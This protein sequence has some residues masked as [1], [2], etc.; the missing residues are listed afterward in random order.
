MEWETGIKPRDED[1]RRVVETKERLSPGAVIGSGLF[2]RAE[3][4][5]SKR[6][7][8][9]VLT[10]KRSAG[11]SDAGIRDD[12]IGGGKDAGI[13]SGRECCL[14]STGLSN[15]RPGSHGTAGVGKS[16]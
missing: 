16:K 2:L 7:E 15:R 9:T 13:G 3:L 8:R 4:V 14:R 1:A 5:R 6:W 12:S 10:E 11:E